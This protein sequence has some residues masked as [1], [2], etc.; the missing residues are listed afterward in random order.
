MKINLV[1]GIYNIGLFVF[2]LLWIRDP[3]FL[4]AYIGDSFDFPLFGFVLGVC[5]SSIINDGITFMVKAYVKLFHK[6]AREQEEKIKMFIDKEK[7]KKE[8][9]KKRLLNEERYNRNRYEDTFTS[10]RSAYNE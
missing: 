7:K 4:N 6:T 3:T 10:L 5:F 1:S 9:K 2:M 8:D